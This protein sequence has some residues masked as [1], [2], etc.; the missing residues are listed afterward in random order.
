MG[1]YGYFDDERREYVITDPRT[2]VKWINYIGTL[3]FGGIVD[4]TGGALL[5]G[6]DPAL[7]RIVKYVPQLPSSEFKGETLYLRLKEGDAYRVFSPFFVPTLDAYEQFECRVGLSYQHFV[8]VFHG[9]RCEV[10]VFVPPGEPV[11]I[12]D[13]RITNETGGPVELDAVPVVEFTH[14]QAF[15]QFNN[16]D[17]VPQT[18]MCEA[19]R[20]PDG[21]IVIRQF[22][23]MRKDALVNYVTSN[24]PVD[25]FQTDRKRF[26]GR[27]EYGTWQHPLELQEEHL[28]DYEARRGDVMSALLH[29]LG[30]VPAGGTRR[31]IT[32]LGQAHP[33]KIAPTV[34]RF[35]REEEVDAAFAGAARLLGPVPGPVGLPRRR[36]PP[37]IPWSTFTIRGSAIRP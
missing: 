2:P 35:R 27:H 32:L 34:E 14:F 22:A 36:T 21:K 15:K 17:W 23:F 10:I 24:Q 16:A 20:E 9:I 12:R 19:D 29:R 5:C 28:S 7:N 33:D 37:S 30:T 1:M 11:E 25:S 13:I 26:P 4:H 18:M 31:L 8:T 3:P 6:G